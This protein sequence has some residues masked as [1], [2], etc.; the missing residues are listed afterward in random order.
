MSLG[1]STNNRLH[2]PYHYHIVKDA[3]IPT[4]TFHGDVYFAEAFEGHTVSS[5]P[6]KMMIEASSHKGA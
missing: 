3:S 6:T 4:Q 5:Q 2:V 1:H